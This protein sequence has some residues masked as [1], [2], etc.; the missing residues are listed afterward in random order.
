M[1][2]SFQFVMHDEL[3]LDQAQRALAAFTKVKWS[4]VSDVLASE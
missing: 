4:R 2:N 1:Y 3:H